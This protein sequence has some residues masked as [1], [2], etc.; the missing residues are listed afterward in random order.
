MFAN[1]LISLYLLLERIPAV[2][3]V[4]LILNISQTCSWGNRPILKDL[5]KQKVMAKASSEGG[6]DSFFM[7][8]NQAVQAGATVNPIVV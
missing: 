5:R 1:K 4:T 2:Y 8:A 3:G 7:H 6:S